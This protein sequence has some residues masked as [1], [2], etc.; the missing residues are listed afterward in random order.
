MAGC[1]VKAL[2]HAAVLFA[3]G[4]N[5][6]VPVTERILHADNILHRRRNATNAH[7]RIIDAL[8][9]HAQLLVIVHVLQAAAAAGA[10]NRAGRLRACRGRG[11]ALLRLT[12][13]GICR[14]LQDADLPRL[15]DECAF[16]EHGAA[17]NVAHTRAVGRIA[18]DPRGMQLIFRKLLHAY[19]AS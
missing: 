15:T 16:H 14:H 18:R 11:Q 1:A 4:V 17:G 8:K 6:F 12:V 10:V 7:E 19:S 9:L 2:D 3:D 5:R 13:D